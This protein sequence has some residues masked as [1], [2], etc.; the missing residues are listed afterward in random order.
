MNIFFSE[1]YRLYAIRGAFSPLRRQLPGDRETLINT[2]CCFSHLHDEE[3]L[4]KHLL[5]REGAWAAKRRQFFMGAEFANTGSEGC[6]PGCVL[7]TFYLLYER[8]DEKWRVPYSSSHLRQDKKGRV[9]SFSSCLLKAKTKRDGSP[10]FYL[11]SE[12]RQKGR[13][14]RLFILSMKDK[15]QRDGSPLFILSF[16]LKDKMKRDDQALSISSMKDKME[17]ARSALSNPCSSCLR[18]DEKGR[19]RP[20]HLVY[21]REEEKGR[22]VP[23]H[24]IHERQD[25]K[26]RKDKT[27]RDNPALS[28]LSIQ[29]SP[30]HP[31][32][33]LFE[34][35]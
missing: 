32:F 23:F 26:G 18:Q 10:P 5:A 21:E 2:A 35:R 17:R 28:F 14:P 25:E 27:K 6:R 9:S 30:L 1:K 11:V 24:L 34:T 33:I 4:L 7:A 19:S 15:T 13:G 20:F 8:Q 16:S 29:I 22:V 3:K 31:L 12:I